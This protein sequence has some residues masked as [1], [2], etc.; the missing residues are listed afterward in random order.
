[1]AASSGSSETRP[2]NSDSSEVSTS[3]RPGNTVA[4]PLY[5]CQQHA[6]K[7]GLRRQ[8]AVE[9][10]VVMPHQEQQFS[11]TGGIVQH[12]RRGEITQQTGHRPFRHANE[13]PGLLVGIGQ[14]APAPRPMRR[15][16]P[17]VATAAPRHPAQTATASPGSALPVADGKP[18]LGATDCRNVR[19]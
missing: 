5:H 8:P 14:Q 4:S 11:V 6:F 1:L 19:V 16:I 9:A 17:P 18:S 2:G 12:H 10:V 7:Q 3:S 15:L 13:N